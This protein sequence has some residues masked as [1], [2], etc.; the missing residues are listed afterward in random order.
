MV[1]VCPILWSWI[2]VKAL[3][4]NLYQLIIWLKS[5]HFGESTQ[6]LGVLCLWQRFRTYFDIHKIP[7]FKYNVSSN[8]LSNLDLQGLAVK[9]INFQLWQAVP[10]AANMLNTLVQQSQKHDTDW[11]NC[12]GR[13]FYTR[14]GRW[15][16]KFKNNLLHAISTKQSGPIS[17]LHK[18]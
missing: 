8:M 4:L 16:V 17:N 5:G 11:S 6:P 7:L 15:T 2:L 18:I 13:D 1:E 14:K 12:F 3:R 9:K 10:P